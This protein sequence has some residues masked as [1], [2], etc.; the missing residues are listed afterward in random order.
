MIRRE[1][2]ALK[3]DNS[4]AATLKGAELKED[5]E[6]ADEVKR[7]GEF[8]REFYGTATLSQEQLFESLKRTRDRL[9]RRGWKHMIGIM[10]PRPF[11]PRVVHV[12]VP[13]PIRVSAVGPAHA[14]DY[15]TS[16]LALTRARMQEKLDE[17]NARI[18]PD[19]EGENSK[20]GIF[21]VRRY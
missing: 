13:Q 16:L 7:L 20:T 15:E 1:L 18:A 14:G 10:L 2:S 8:S 17:I 6:M 19:V 21:V 12:G 11:G 3:G 5:M 4:S 9:L